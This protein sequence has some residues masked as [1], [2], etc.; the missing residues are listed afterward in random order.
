MY[1]STFYSKHSLY[2]LLAI[3][4]TFS[5]TKEEAVVEESEHSASPTINFRT[6][7]NNILDQIEFDGDMF[8]F[9]AWEDFVATETYLTEL[10]VEHNE[11]FGE[12]YAELD[13]EAYNQLVY[14]LDFS[15][16]QPLTDFEEQFGI[17][18]K[19]QQINE[20]VEIWLTETGDTPDV[21]T[22]PDHFPI[23]AQQTRSL[24]NEQ[25]Q[26]KIAG[27]IVQIDDVVIT[28]DDN[29][30]YHPCLEE[31][32]TRRSQ[33]FATSSGNT[34]FVIHTS[35]VAMIIPNVFKRAETTATAFQFGGR[36]GP[37][38]IKTTLKMTGFASSDCDRTNLYP[39]SPIDNYSYI[40]FSQRSVFHN[41]SHTNHP[42]FYVCDIGAHF[43]HGPYLMQHCTGYR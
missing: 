28:T 16:F 27:E 3:L 39:I 5:C 2:S 36:R 38:L 17:Q 43:G 8:V 18:S 34:L 24:F 35:A 21:N 15:D 9:D 26:V 41:Y 1:T 13:D 29:P 37:F 25:G 7:H 40:R 19:R 22:Y 20:L 14:E 33:S 10:V 4:F 11:T 31:G 30:L 23:L 42:K 32:Y 6:T 12:P